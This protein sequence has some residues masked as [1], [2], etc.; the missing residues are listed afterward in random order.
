MNDSERHAEVQA[1][2]GEA[3]AGLME[4]E[5]AREAEAQSLRIAKQEEK[6]RQELV[7]MKEAV[8]AI[9]EALAKPVTEPEPE[10]T[11][12]APAEF[13]Q[14]ETQVAS[15]DGS[16]LEADPNGMTPVIEFLSSESQA[17]IRPVP[18][19]GSVI[20]GRPA[21]RAARNLR[22]SRPVKVSRPQSRGFW[23]M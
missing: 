5:D 3:L 7:R 12:E 22:A 11:A 4:R 23:Q 21:G 15:T 9:A 14:G 8:P 2:K 1:S 10:A 6:A 19:R 18:R 20:A 17:G 16:R 13:P